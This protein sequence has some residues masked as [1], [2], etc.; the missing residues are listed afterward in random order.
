MK[1]SNNSIEHMFA[2][3]TAGLCSTIILNP[4]DV[5]KTRYQVH[6]ERGNAYTSVWNAV[7]TIARTEG[8]RGFCLGLLPASLAS[9]ISWGGYLY[10]YELSKNRKLQYLNRNNNNNNQIKLSSFDVLL[11]GVEAGSIMVF[12]TNPLW[13]IKTRLQLQ[14]E[15]AHVEYKYNGFIDAFKTIIKKEGGIFALYRGILPALFLTTHGAIQFAT[16]EYLKTKVEILGWANIMHKIHNNNDITSRAE[17]PMKITAI[18]GIFSKLVATTVTYPYQ[19]IKSRLQQRD[20]Y[21]E[22]NSTIENNNAHKNKIM[23]KTLSNNRYILRAKYNGMFDCII[24]IIK[25][26]GYRGFY[27]GYIA[28]CIKVAPTAA[29]TLSVYEYVLNVLFR[30]KK[31]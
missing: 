7:S 4:I 13:L 1:N 28:N 15:N 8:I 9:A 22:K 5:I 20:T 27:K 11:S 12:I 10:F 14:L 30:N 6:S 31:E 29:I 21:I 2:G 16:Y 24:Q 23:N 26:E 18:L 19:V 3:I 25:N 17:I